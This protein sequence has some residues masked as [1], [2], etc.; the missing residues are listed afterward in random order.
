M[1]FYAFL[2]ESFFDSKSAMDTITKITSFL[3]SNKSTFS[4]PIFFNYVSDKLENILT[5]F[6]F[7][8]SY[9][10]SFYL[11]RLIRKS[12]NNGPLHSCV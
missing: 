10:I 11:L 5:G 6:K 7:I 1:K 4:F 8:L 2:K 9:I 12:K 3:V